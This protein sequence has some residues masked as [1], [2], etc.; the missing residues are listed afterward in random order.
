M[1]KKKNDIDPVD[2][3]QIQELISKQK[4]GEAINKLNKI[5]ASDKNNA[6][7]QALLEHLKKI[8][9]YQNKDIFSSTNLNM[10]PWLE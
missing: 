2:F 5:K 7:V 6:E 10:D 8:V 4:F 1:R 9:E 3:S